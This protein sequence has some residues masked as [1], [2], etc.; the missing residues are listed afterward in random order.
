MKR[1]YTKEWFLNRAK[2]LRELVPDVSISTDV[3]VA[4]PT[5]SDEDFL[6]TLEVVKEV[7][8]EQMF[9]FKY[10]PR[11]LTPAKDLKQVDVEVAEKR[12]KTLQDLQTTI[13]DEITLSK[14]D[15]IFDVYFEELRS[16]GGVSGR[17]DNNFSVQVQ[18]SDELLGLTKKVKITNPRRMVLYGE[19]V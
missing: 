16:G 7:R 13:L 19:V 8:F 15:Q 18:G 9:S 12:L 6:E 14:K 10:S 5:E 11:P 4:F 1:G 17:S 3:I 2:K